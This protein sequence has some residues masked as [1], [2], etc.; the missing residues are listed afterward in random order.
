MNIECQTVLLR[1]LNAAVVLD[2]VGWANLPSLIA[3][4]VPA[5]AHSVTPAAEMLSVHDFSEFAFTTPLPI[6]GPKFNWWSTVQQC[7]FVVFI[8]KIER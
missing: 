1:T 8:T 4:N 2:A 6:C 5:P 3:P 7:V